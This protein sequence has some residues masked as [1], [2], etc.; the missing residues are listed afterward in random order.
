[1]N[2]EFLSVMGHREK[3]ND[4]KLSL[5]ATGKLQLR[6]FRR[7]ARWCRDEECL[8]PVE[9]GDRSFAGAYVPAFPRLP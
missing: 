8:V 2:G 1:M 5:A 3:L 6:P 4:V 7:G 9:S